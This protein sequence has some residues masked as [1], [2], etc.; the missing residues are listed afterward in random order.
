M[1]VVR[2]PDEIVYDK[3]TVVTVGTFDGVHIGHQQIIGELNRLKEEKNLRSI[4]ITFDPH[5]QIV[6]RN[7]SKDVKLLTSTE[8]KLEL[9]KK[10]PLDTV[11]IINFSKEFAATPAETFF[12]DYIVNRIGLN[13]LVI[14]YDH[15][16]GKNREGSIE[17]VNA[18]SNKF[19]FSVHKV[20]EFKI[21]DKNISSTE[22]RKLLEEGDV[23]AAKFFLGRFY[24][25]EGT[26]V[27]GAKRG[28]ELGYPTANLQ[29]EDD[30]KQIPKNGIY[31]VEVLYDKNIFR[32][33]MSIGHNPTVN[34]TDEIFLEV[35]IFNFDKD[36]YGEKIKIRFV[37][38][39]R[40]EVKFNSLEELTKKL[41]EDKQKT[42]NI[43]SN[44]N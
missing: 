16:F 22:I 2:E 31:A 34:D 40:E 9:L 41:D 25:I 36:I 15:M 3:K 29:I 44:I 28:R 7:R 19:G 1:I 33:M 26:I 13:D 39:I 38:Y 24:E 30:N 35:N 14:G 11:Y 18:L 17:T 42:L 27:Q 4:L 20:P 6:L 5:P 12:T 32:G 21:D 8:E 37:E 43:F 10:F 23:N